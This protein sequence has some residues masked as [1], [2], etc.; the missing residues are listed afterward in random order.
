MQL[1]CLDSALVSKPI[2]DRFQRVLLAAPPAVARPCAPNGGGGGGPAGAKYI[3]RLLG[4]EAAV[5]GHRLVI[6]LFRWRSVRLAL[7]RRC[8]RLLRRRDAPSPF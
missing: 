8:F 6:D 2:F 1:A 5:S 7:V 4:F 3:P